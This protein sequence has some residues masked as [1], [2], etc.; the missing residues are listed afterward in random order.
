M[1]A[2]ARIENMKWYNK[3]F[4]VLIAIAILFGIFWLQ[5]RF[6]HSISIFHSVDY[7]NFKYDKKEKTDDG[8]KYSYSFSNSKKEEKSFV[9]VTA[10]YNNNI[11]TI[12]APFGSMR[13]EKVKENEIADASAI[14]YYTKETPFS[15]S[16]VSFIDKYNLTDLSTEKQK[17]IFKD[18][19]ESGFDFGWN[20]VS[21]LSSVIS[22]DKYNIWLFYLTC[23]SVVTIIGFLY[24]FFAGRWNYFGIIAR[25]HLVNGVT[26]AGFF[27]ISLLFAFRFTF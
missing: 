20:F 16:Q 19:N 13:F 10:K 24:M 6:G 2:Y 11:Y 4:M 17:Q 26:A 12:D 5:P 7:I 1:Y 18:M 27:I 23:I 3:V 25:T 9:T 22:A 21:F 8:Y 15:M 14:D